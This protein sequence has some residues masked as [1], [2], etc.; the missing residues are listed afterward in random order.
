[1][2]LTLLLLAILIPVGACLAAIL[3]ALRLREDEVVVA[4]SGF[5]VVRD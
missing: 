4:A 3:L 2:D 1:V 5:V